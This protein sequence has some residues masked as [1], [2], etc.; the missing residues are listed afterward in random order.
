VAAAVAAARRGL[1]VELD[2]A[3]SGLGGVLTSAMMDQWDLNTGPSGA[4][5][6]RGI[7]SEIAA[8]LGD[9]FTPEHAQAALATLVAQNPGID[10]RYG[11]QPASVF[12]EPTSAGR[13]VT[14]IV[15][16]TKDGTCSSL[17]P[18]V[19]DAT[20]D[21]DVAALAGARYD[22]GRQDTGHDAAMQAATLMFALRDVDVHELFTGYNAALFGPG[23][24]LGSRVWGFSRLMRAYRPADPSI[25]V[26]DLN[27]GVTPEGE[28]TVNAIDILGVNGLD[29]R[30][31]DD[32]MASAKAET[33]RLIAFLRGRVPGFE[34]ARLSR[35]AQTLYIRET[36]H[37]LGLAYLTA[38]DVWDG[39]IPADTIGMSSYPLDLH[40]V[41]AN[42]TQAYA[43]VRHVYGIP[44]GAL[45]PAGFA[46]L[47]L[48]SRA[49][50]A[51]HVAAGSAR[52][53]PTTIEEGEAA[54]AACA[55]ALQDR[56]TL[57]ELDRSK[58][59]IA[60]LRTD[61]TGRGVVLAPA[62]SDRPALRA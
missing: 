11:L 54:G 34:N 39:R 42:D 6:E 53:V 60:Q 43:P 40:P 22:L 57:E 5:I 2:V 3:Q 7:F 33:P 21:G 58:E 8:E 18:F 12:V 14:R 1:H 31:V 29:P 49:I 9:A 37:V 62:P 27:L 15:F 55:L 17:A 44:L 38:T 32:G 28:I 50:S 52:I 61:L 47:I 25:V 48:V 24:A 59:L 10:V 51:S 20:D 26:R 35:F 30:S 13:Y 56:I 41:T 4:V 45:I 23:G 46:N 36:R 19:I 16:R